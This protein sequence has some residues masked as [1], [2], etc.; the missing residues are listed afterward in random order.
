MCRIFSFIL[1]INRYLGD[2]NHVVVVV[3]IDV[4]VKYLDS[5][6]IDSR[7]IDDQIRDQS[8]LFVV[9]VAF[10][11]VSLTSFYHLK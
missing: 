11:S 9:V 7:S 3:V 5:T 6:K 2:L 10:I 4:N 1:K 8:S